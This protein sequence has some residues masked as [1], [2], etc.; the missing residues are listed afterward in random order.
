MDKTLWQN[1]VA[2]HGHSCFGLAIGYHVATAALQTLSTLRDIDE[3]MIAIVENDNCSVDAIQFITGCTIG[4][5]NLIL[6]DYGKVVY[7]FYLRKKKKGIRITVAG[8]DMSDY[9]EV[10]ALKEKIAEGGAS[11]AE[12]ALHAQKSEE[13]IFHYLSKPTE[14]VC[15][16]SE[17]VW[18][19][20]EKARRFPTLTCNYCGEAVME[21]RARIKGGKISCIPCAD[22]YSRS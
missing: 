6:R 3:E 12:K 16:I 9:P 11:T 19:L 7:T 14:A 10:A 17:P 8:P 13:A 22:A 18:D 1:V 21:P 4:K 5:G 20:P 2:F 15:K